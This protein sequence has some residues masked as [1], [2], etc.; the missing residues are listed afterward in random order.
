MLKIKVN[1]REEKVYIGCR[2]FVSL[3]ELLKILDT[4]HTELL[5]N[6]TAVEYERFAHTN[7]Y[8][9]DALTLA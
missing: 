2:T 7:V 3:D 4:G 9:G 6:G 5:H 8:A 1:G